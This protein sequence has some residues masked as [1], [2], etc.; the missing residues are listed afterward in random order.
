MRLAAA[1]PVVLVLVLAMPLPWTGGRAGPAR[2]WTVTDYQRL[3]DGILFLEENLTVA[4]GGR[5]EL[6]NM[7]VRFNSSGPGPMVLEVRAGGELVLVDSLLTG[8]G[9]GPFVVRALPGSRLS[10][11]GCDISGAGTCATDPLGAG[12][13]VA[14][15][16]AS[17][18]NTTFR[19]R[20]CSLYLLD[21]SPVV[22]DSDFPG[23]GTGAVLDGSNSTFLRSRFGSRE[24]PAMR[25]VNGSSG[26]ALDTDIDPG[27][28]SAD[29]TSVLDIAW[30]LSVFV[31]WDTGRPA[32]G[33]LVRVAPSDGP[34]APYV[35]NATGM[36]T[37]IRAIST[38]VS[39][40]GTAAHGPFNVSA[41]SEGRA[42]WELADISIGADIA[43]VLDGTPPQVFILFPV[44][45]SVLNAS[46]PPA[47][48]TAWDPLRNDDRP[49]L[50]AVEATLDGGPWRPANGTSE[51]SFCLS[52]LPE[53]VH[54][55]TVRAR[56]L[57]GNDN[58][59]SV[60]FTVDLTPPFLSVW[61][62]PGHLTSALNLTVLIRTNGDRVLLNGT[63]VEGSSGTYEAEWAL[64][65][66]GNNTAVVESRDI[67][68]NLARVDLSVERDTLPPDVRFLS[69]PQFSVHATPLVTVSGTAADRNGV[70]L[71][72]WGPD[73][74]NWTRVNGTA[75]WSF[76]VVLS[77]GENTV[78]VRATDG[79]GN[80]GVGWLRL[81]LRLPDTKPPEISVLYPLDGQTV[82]TPEVEF[83]G[84]ANDA[85]GLARVQLS[86]DGLAWTDAVGTADWSCRLTLSEG[87]NTVLVR[88]ADTAG[89]LNSTFLSVT[90]APP[91]PDTAPP[92]LSV[93]Y[94]PRGLRLPVAKVVVSGRVSDPSGIAS[95]EL[96]TDGRTWRSCIVT[97]ED[98]SGTATL[99]PG[100]NTISV[101][102][103]D[104]AGNRA[105]ASTVAVYESPRDPSADRGAFS[106]ALAL[107]AL[108]LLAAWLLV[109]R[110]A[111]KA[112]ASRRARAE[113]E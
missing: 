26:L 109:R 75:G 27:R 113:E 13:L 56:D 65:S 112:P 50:E 99:G 40:S 44:E 97:G 57:S 19:D 39:A 90:Y 52:D 23:N 101:R 71:V 96:S 42:A 59:T 7:V 25:L 3:S 103:L 30:S 2:E 106:L 31:R 67:A 41:E 17:V 5:L 35:A 28:V 82:G 80:A 6:D 49:G 16:L 36:V 33:A 1:V 94:P 24:G 11:G 70:A 92:A 98:W 66:E 55:L 89:N 15:S 29:D 8:N 18:S 110:P 47:S 34:A 45:G 111:R 84:R 61:P 87:N 22:A 9:T 58:A 108:G 88:A 10:V 38:S 64:E 46:A 95:V 62:P 79:A 104:T 93:L 54:T 32:G 76:P 105:E 85:G 37:G 43:L 53:G 14:T 4:A 69:P 72:E 21:C 102:A 78:Y 51:W 83:S 81:D 91:P 12:L 63:P 86:L 20:P 107:L 60:S 48:G 74:R 100:R 77:E 73:R 68:G